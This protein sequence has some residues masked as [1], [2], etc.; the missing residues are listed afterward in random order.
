MSDVNKAVAEMN[1]SS[2]YRTLMSASLQ[3]RTFL[4]AV[5]KALDKN[6]TG[7]T[8]MTEVSV[9]LPFACGNLY[10]IHA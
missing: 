1:A 9:V 10:R 8:D 5:M 4:L 3:Q 7:Q 6:G 2:T